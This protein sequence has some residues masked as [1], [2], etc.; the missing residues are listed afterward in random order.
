MPWRFN[1]ASSGLFLFTWCI[2]HV[3]AS[4][5]PGATGMPIDFPDPW[6]VAV[7]VDRLLGIVPKVTQI[8]L[9]A[10]D[11]APCQPG[12][13]ISGVRVAIAWVVVLL[14]S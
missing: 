14:L 12:L 5:E 1:V 7:E 3:G 9:R 4:W 13:P 8:N 11:R 10:I 6:F 2:C